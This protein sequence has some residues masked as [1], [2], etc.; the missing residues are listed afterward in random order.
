MIENGEIGVVSVIDLSRVGRN[1]L[2]VG[3][4]LEIKYPPLG[5]RF[6][7]IQENVD[8]LKNTGTEM[9]PFNNIFNEWYAAQT[10]KKIRAVWKS[11]ADKGERVASAVP[12][13]YKK[14]EDDPKQWV[15]DEPAANTVRRIFALCIEG[16]GPTK[17]A[18][19]LEA[20]R[21]M[22]PT[23]YQL[24]VGRKTF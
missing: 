13:G 7:A 18:R 6:I 8:T 11:K 24:S 16:L 23:S 21:F 10:S 2:D 5:V 22:N 20:E 15:V 4:Y 14:S 1:F 17:I 3:E 19:R 12:F 9:M